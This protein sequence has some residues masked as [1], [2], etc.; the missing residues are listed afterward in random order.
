M[1]QENAF[2]TMGGA[3]IRWQDRHALEDALFEGLPDD[4]VDLLIERAIDLHGDDAV[5]ANIKSKSAGRLSLADIRAERARGGY[6]QETRKALGEASRQNG[7]R[8]GKTGW[9]KTIAFMEDVAFEVVLPCS[10]R[11][12]T[13]FKRRVIDL[14]KWIKSAG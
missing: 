5:D 12:T 9:F 13:E 10:K 11:C 8:A 14:L 3:V 7:G 6:S 2:S 1:V 4:A